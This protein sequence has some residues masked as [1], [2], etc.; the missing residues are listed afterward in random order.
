[1]ND[2]EAFIEWCYINNEKKKLLKFNIKNN[3]IYK[4][5][6]FIINECVN[7]KFNQEIEG[8]NKCYIEDD[9]SLKMTII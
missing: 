7:K 9:I 3:N 2:Y 8:I 5:A 4:F 1:M 6:I